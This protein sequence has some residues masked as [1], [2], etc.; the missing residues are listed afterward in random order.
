[1]A[2]RKSQLLEILYSQGPAAAVL[3]A[4]AKHRDRGLAGDLR[5]P[6][7]AIVGQAEM[8]IALLLA[9]INRAVGGC[10]RHGQNYGG[11][12]SG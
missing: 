6:F 7:L 10:S 3:K 5:Y 2:K 9:L 12:R 4:A 11:T 1:M 8:K